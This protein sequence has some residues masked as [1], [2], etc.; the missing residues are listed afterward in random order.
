MLANTEAALK[1]EKYERTNIKEQY[2]LK[3]ILIRRKFKI[4]F[5]LKA[6]K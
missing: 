4:A 5:F 3:N 2:Q 1:T 6:L